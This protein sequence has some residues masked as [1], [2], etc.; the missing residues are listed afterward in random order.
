MTGRICST[1]IF[2]DRLSTVR[3][4]NMTCHTDLANLRPQ[5]AIPF[6]GFFLGLAIR[7]SALTLLGSWFFSR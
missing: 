1:P 5:S 6:N 2:I 3:R 7:Y 4:L